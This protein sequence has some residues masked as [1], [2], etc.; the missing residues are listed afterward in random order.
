MWDTFGLD[1]LGWLCFH[2]TIAEGV[3][4]EVATRIEL[5]DSGLIARWAAC[6]RPVPIELARLAPADA[7]EVALL[8]YDVRSA[9]TLLREALEGQVQFAFLDMVMRPSTDLQHLGQF[10]PPMKSPQYVVFT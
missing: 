6:A 8:G 3:A 2:A 4:T 10:I 5:P 1:G 7:I 9:W